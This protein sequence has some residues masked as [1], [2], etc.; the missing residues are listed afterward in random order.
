M[1]SACSSISYIAHTSTEHLEL[2]R[3]RTPITKALNSDE[4]S[5][6]RKQLLQK[7]LQIRK[8]ASEELGLPENASYTT[9]V[10]LDR[11]YV[12]WV[13]FASEEFSLQAKT[14]CFWIVGCVPYR[15][16]F[17][18]AKAQ[19]FAMHLKQQ[20]L[21]VYIAPVPAYSTLGWFSDPILSSML[22]QGEIV[23]AEYIFH[24]LAHQQLYIKDDADFNEAFA[25]AVG[26]LGVVSWLLAESKN[27]ELERYQKKIKIKEE[28]YQQV[29][30]LRNNLEQIYSSSASIE[31]KRKSKKAAHKK[32]REDIHA[33][34]GDVSNSTAYESW[35]F[36]NLNN[37]KLNALS[38]YQ[39]MVPEFIQLF[40]KCSQEFQLF[41]STVDQLKKMPKDQ[42]ATSLDDYPCMQEG[43]L[44]P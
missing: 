35:L 1:L 19:D 34:L 23:A 33:L 5:P 21:E 24:E 18:V 42:R 13:V 27:D 12:T 4:I 2:M 31:D 36:A 7:V 6:E 37:A 30:Q 38:T 44:T 9:Y 8:F 43:L 3:K 40:E 29:D 25:T 28:I 32:F 22:N 14:W 15:G 41:Y 16:Y 26:Q 11:E 39:S 20:G 10:E 17:D